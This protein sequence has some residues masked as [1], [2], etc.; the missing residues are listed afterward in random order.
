MTPCESAAYV[1]I[2][3]PPQTLTYPFFVSLRIHS[4]IPK[5]PNSTALVHKTKG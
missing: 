4:S 5:S 3:R 1:W 2:Q